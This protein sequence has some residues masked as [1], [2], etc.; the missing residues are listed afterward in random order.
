MHHASKCGNKMAKSLLA[1]S[2]TFTH[3]V[4]IHL[5]HSFAIVCLLVAGPKPCNLVHI[6]ADMSGQ[7]LTRGLELVVC[8]RDGGAFRWMPH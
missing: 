8:A 3:C 5:T 6:P 7:S 2:P 4:G 1:P